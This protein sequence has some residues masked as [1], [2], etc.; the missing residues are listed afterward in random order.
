M[1]FKFIPAIDL[2]N[3]QVVR[4]FQG[5]YE[6]VTV[7]SD[8]PAAIVESFI[9][10]GASLI[11]VVDLNA[12]RDGDR[13]IN[14]KSILSIVERIR[15]RAVME[16]GGGI[17]DT[18]ALSFYSDAGINRMIIG[19]GSVTDPAFLKKA[20]SIYGGQRII[21]GVDARD[22]MVKISGWE[23]DSG[24]HIQ[25][26]IPFLAGEGVEEII[27]TDIKTDGALSGPA[28]ESLK[29]VFALSNLRVIASGGIS[30]LHDISALLSLNEKKLTGAISGRAIFEKRINVKDA[31]LLTK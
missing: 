27:F 30:S 10:D 6:D 23:K 15:G 26:F 16:L 29:E 9:N 11:H 19:T 7:Y 20:L 12:A 2:Y 5:K 4:L 17:R 28:I 8:D 24:K 22:G 21:A 1:G 3:N 14:K 18:D 31:V 25:D 13:S